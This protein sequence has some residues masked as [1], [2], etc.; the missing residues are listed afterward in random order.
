MRSVELFAGAGGLAMGMSRA[1][2]KHAAVV[3]WNHDACETFRENQRLHAPGVESWPLYEEDARAFDYSKVRK[4]VVVVSGGPPCQ[5]FSLGGKHRGQM[6]ER[7]MFPEAVRAVRELQPKAF[8]FENVKGLLRQSFASYFEYIYLQLSHPELTRRKSETW[9]QH[10]SRLERHQTSRRTQP[11]YNVV[12]RLLNAADYGVPQRRERVFLVGFRSDLGLEWS[13]PNPTHSKNA[14]LR[15]QWVTGDYW[16][17]HRVAKKT[18]PVLDP[19]Q[20]KQILRIANGDLFEDELPWQTVRDAISDL[21]NPE[22][23]RHH[24]VANHVINPGARSYKGHTGSPLDEPAKT[25]KAGDHGVPGG[26]NMLVR[27]DGTV[28][29]FTVRESAR[30]QTFPDGYIFRGSWSEAMRQLGNAVPVR[31]AET[32]AASVAERLKATTTKVKKGGQRA[33]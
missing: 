8:I 15:D 1:G 13:F 14:L 9:E 27:T 17:R 23:R 30:L 6:D 11:S 7:D 28:R 16:E 33:A 2:F 25:L 31:L 5:P 10:R 24:S 12:F 3:E 18:R 32:I 29:Y 4:D 21:P 20:H 26:E 19:R 22:S